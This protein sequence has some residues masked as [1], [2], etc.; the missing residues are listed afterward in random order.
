MG[1][2]TIICKY[3]GNPS[4]KWPYEVR[5]GTAKYCSH[6]CC[7]NDNPPSE[8]SIKKGI[9]KARETFRKNGHPLAGRHKSKES[10]EK[11]RKALIGRTR[12]EE[13][14]KNISIGLKGKMAGSKHPQ[15][16]GGVVKGSRKTRRSTEYR[17]WRKAVFERDN[18]TCQKCG[19][20]IGGNLN[21]HHVI[22]FYK[23]KTKRMLIE[24]GITLC[25]KCHTKE[26][27]NA[28]DRFAHLL[29]YSY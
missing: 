29:N 16:K 23:D 12:T 2:V 22:Y 28:G 21:A 8:E 17:N 10:V 7:F 13:H 19:D 24:N 15:W 20:N 3:C 26:H 25:K 6:L 4:L 27:V 18:Y 11:M 1:K 5:R 14:K 9:E